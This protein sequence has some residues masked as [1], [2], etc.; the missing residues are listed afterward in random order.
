VGKPTGFLEIERDTPEKRSVEERLRDYREVYLPF[1]EKDLRDQAARCMDCGIPF[2]HDGCPLGNRIPD[3]ND[4]VYRGR[5]REASERLHATNNFPEL[6]GRLC[7]APCEAA[8][9]VGI[10]DEAVSIKV[11]EQAIVDR[12]FAEGYV[13]PQPAAERTHKS[14]AIVGSGP[15]GL[16]CAQ[17]L[18]RRGHDV[19]VFEKADRVGGL[20]RYGIPD[21]KMDKALLDRRLSQLVRE[22]VVFR[23]GVTVGRDVTAEELVRDFDA[24]CLAV[25]AEAPRDVVVPGRDLAG[26]HF[27]MEYLEQQNRIIA[28]DAVGAD[29]RISAEGKRVVI[30]GGG[31]TG[32]D[33]LGTAL[34]QGARDVLQLEIAARPPD[35]RSAA[36]PWPRWPNVFRVSPAHEEGGRR[37]YAIMTTAFSGEDGRVRK[38][39]AVTVSERL[40][41]DASGAR[42]SVFEPIAG[43]EHEIETDLVLLAAGFTGVRPS[44]L[45]AELGVSVDARGRV[46]GDGNGRTTQRT[47]YAA[48]DARRGASL[49]VWAIA[50]GRSAARAIDEDLSGK[51]SLPI[52][53]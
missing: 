16:A 14:V 23:T 2:C 50:E 6:T 35:T 24:I 22:G 20:L 45:F 11:V 9:V 31:D 53:A 33:C 12:A 52:V 28:G 38:L 26:I 4:L 30:L 29:Q 27:A 3:W 7:P 39:H 19:V 25:G 17:E 44:P 1:P 40:V 8:C 41:E 47:V 51:V 5:F 13:A 42:R 43:T 32:A 15:A 34:R 36:D 10:D 21:F 49:I 46:L 37:A 48:G 18:A